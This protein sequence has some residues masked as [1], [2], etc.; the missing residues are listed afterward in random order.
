MSKI[1]RFS[2]KALATIYPVTRDDWTNSDV[3]GEPYLI[4]CA[5]QFVDG[6]ASNGNGYEE[7]ETIIVFTEMLHGM[8]Q[9]PIPKAGDYIALGDT[10]KENNPLHAGGNK[11]TGITTWDMSLFNDTPDYKIITGYQWTGG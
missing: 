10:T 3:Y 5:W 2:Y 7:S 1:A 11:I 8:E 4:D 9:Q 6:G